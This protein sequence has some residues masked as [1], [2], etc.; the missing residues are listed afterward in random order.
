MPSEKEVGAARWRIGTYVEKK[1]G[2]S[3]RGRVCGYYS[4]S[5]TPI[6]YAV[7]SIYDP[8]AV[9]IWPEAA[10]ERKEEPNIHYPRDEIIAQRG[11]APNG[12]AGPD[13]F[14]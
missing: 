13:Q 14:P 2:S 7:E 10:L 3:W 4:T 9:Q 12:G 11:E 6:G 5:N 1:F 8:G